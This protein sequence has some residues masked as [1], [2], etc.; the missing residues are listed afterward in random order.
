MSSKRVRQS[1]HIL[2]YC[3]L[4]GSFYHRHIDVL[5][6]SYEVNVTLYFIVREKITKQVDI[7]FL[8]FIIYICE[9]S[10]RMDIWDQWQLIRMSEIG[11][12]FVNNNFFF[13]TV[14]LKLAKFRVFDLC[15]WFYLKLGLFI[16]LSRNLLKSLPW[17]FWYLTN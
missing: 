14:Y 2:F 3:R 15:C 1:Q 7:G 12:S 16:L 4:P 8:D 11:C 10:L 5:K 13:F 6:R 9:S 17:F